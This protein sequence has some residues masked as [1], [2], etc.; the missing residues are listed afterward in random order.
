MQIGNLSAFEIH[1]LLKDKKISPV[2]VYKFFLSEIREK[3][4]DINAFIY[5]EEKYADN[6]DKKDWFIPIAIKDNIAVKDL[7]LSCASFILKGF[8]SPYDALL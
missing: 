8:K 7:P 5:I 1:K 3:N 6:S 4:K 2:E